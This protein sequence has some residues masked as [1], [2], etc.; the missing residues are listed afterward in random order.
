M[1]QVDNAESYVDIMQQAGVSVDIEVE[2]N[3]IKIL[4]LSLP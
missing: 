1:L 3:L 4:S 2:L